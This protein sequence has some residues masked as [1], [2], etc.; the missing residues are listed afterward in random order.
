[1]KTV[2]QLIEKLKEM[3]MDA[4]VFITYTMCDEDGEEYTPFY[5]CDGLKE[6]KLPS[7]LKEI[8][9]GAFAYYPN[10]KRSCCV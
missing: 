4:P 7:T 8:G 2:A 3:P 10:F 5:E 1:M 6:V 9:E